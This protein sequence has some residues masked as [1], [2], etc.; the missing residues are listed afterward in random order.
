VQTDVLKTLH[1][2][3]DELKSNSGNGSRFPI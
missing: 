3:L 2:I 1:A